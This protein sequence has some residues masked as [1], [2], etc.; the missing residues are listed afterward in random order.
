M[1]FK[2]VTTLNIIQERLT[3]QGLFAED[4]EAKCVGQ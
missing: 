2:P 1:D 3:V 4:N